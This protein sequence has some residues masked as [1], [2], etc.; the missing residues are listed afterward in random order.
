MNRG[1]AGRWV[2]AL[3]VLIVLLAALALQPRGRESMASSPPPSPSPSVIPE[4]RPDAAPARVDAALIHG[5]QPYRY[6]DPERG[7]TVSLADF[8]GAR[9]LSGAVRVVTQWEL[10]NGRGRDTALSW[11]ATAAGPTVAGIVIAVDGPESEPGRAIPGRTQPAPSPHHQVTLWYDATSRHTSTSPALIAPGHWQ[12]FVD[13]VLAHLEKTDELSA[14]SGEDLRT[15]LAADPAPRGDGPALQF[16]AEGDLVLDLGEG[17]RYAV[18]GEQIA[19]HLSELGRRARAASQRPSEISATGDGAPSATPAATPSATP[20]ATPDPTPRA[21]PGG[22]NSATPD[23]TPGERRP[24]AAVGTDCQR[25]NC[26][27]LTY[28]DGPIAGTSDKVLAA[29]TRTGAAATFFQMGQNLRHNAPTGRAIV[30]AGMEVGN[31]TL[32]HPQLTTSHLLEN[33]VHGETELMRQTYGFAPMLMRPPYGA[34]NPSVDRVAGKD[35]QAVIIW[36]VDTEDWK[37]RSGPKTTAAAL[38]GADHPGSIVL[39]HDI[40]DAA[41]EATEGI[42]NELRAR[43]LEPVTVTELSLSDQ[44][45]RAGT[46]YC[47]A[48][49]VGPRGFECTRKMLK[50]RPTGTPSRTVEPAGSGSPTP[51][52]QLPIAPS[53]RPRDTPL[54]DPRGGIVGHRS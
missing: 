22:P 1:G 40:H 49:F 11:T 46:A 13:Q 30:S 4:P 23:A 36:D 48:T 52:G 18:P 16:T 43:G 34:R 17:I 51:T 15:R 47:S 26:I 33:E 31:H 24:S 8:D 14:G 9:N 5:Q 27:A 41:G 28:D 44:A 32:N 3:G 21:A 37:T 54:D 20:A 6:A 10:R 25:V 38:I 2:V 39:M 45:P 29:L 12:P 19:P 7:V 53:T 50:P 35:Q 42:V